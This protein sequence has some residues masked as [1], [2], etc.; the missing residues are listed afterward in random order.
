VYYGEWL[1]F[2]GN[3]VKSDIP[4]QPMETRTSEDTQKY[5]E[6]TKEVEQRYLK[7]ALEHDGVVRRVPVGPHLIA[8]ESPTIARTTYR[9]TAP[10]TDWDDYAALGIPLT[11]KPIPKT[12]NN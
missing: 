1:D 2:A 12:P 7:D 3:V 6:L 8:I 5:P 11:V 9:T 4:Q 10:R